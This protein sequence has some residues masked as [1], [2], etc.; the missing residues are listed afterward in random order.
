MLLQRIFEFLEK[1]LTYA[2]ERVELVYWEWK[3]PKPATPVDRG[4]WH[5]E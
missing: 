2:P 1:L 4:T 5:D 3:Y